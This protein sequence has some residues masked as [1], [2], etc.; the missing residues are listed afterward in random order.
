MF[1]LECLA[2]A[3]KSK[4]TSS[5]TVESVKAERPP[6]ESSVSSTGT[7]FTANSFIR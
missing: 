4:K 1:C 2:S 3:F 5:K 7:V 6:S